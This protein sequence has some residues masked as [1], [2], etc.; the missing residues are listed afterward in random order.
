MIEALPHFHKWIKDNYILTGKNININSTE[1]YKIYYEE[2]K[3]RASKQKLS[4]YINEIGIELK[5]VSE[6]GE[7]QYKYVMSNEDLLESFKNKNWIDPDTDH[8]DIKE[9]PHNFIKKG[10]K[11]YDEIEQLKFEIFNLQSK[12]MEREKQN[13]TK[14][15]FKKITTKDS[16]DEERKNQEKQ[17]ND[18]CKDIDKLIQKK[19]VV[20]KNVSTKRRF[21]HEI[22]S[23]DARK[24]LEDFSKN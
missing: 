16:F 20:K 24:F 15:I 21:M 11:E 10:V 18:I 7:R 22:I 5:R 13:K 3:D 2:T 6:K 1:F 9:D 14:K 12:L 19:K 8:I 17:F 4:K 23:S